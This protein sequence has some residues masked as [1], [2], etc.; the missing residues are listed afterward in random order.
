MVSGSVV[1]VTVDG[2]GCEEAVVDFIKMGPGAVG[3]DMGVEKLLNEAAVSCSA[4]IVLKLK[5]PITFKSVSENVMREK[6]PLPGR[7]I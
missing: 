5:I 7:D 3:I 1:C 2:N 6:P 4:S